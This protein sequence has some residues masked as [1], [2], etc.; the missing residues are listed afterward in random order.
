MKPIYQRLRKRTLQ[1]SSQLPPSE[2]HSDFAWASDR[3]AHTLASHHLVSQL[4]ESIAGIIDDD[5]GHGLHHTL[6]VTLDAGILMLVEGKASGLTG[7]LLDRQMVLAQCAGLLHDVKRK[8]ADHSACGAKFAET[9]LAP[10]PLTPSEI[11]DI[12]LAIRN[13]EA[14][15]AT[16]D[17]A[18]DMGQLVS[19]CLYDAD[20]FQWGPPNFTKTLWDMV[21]YYDPP[22]ESFVAKFPGGMS[23]ITQIRA[24]FRT[25][26]G[27]KYGP[28]IIDQGLAIGNELYRIMKNEFGL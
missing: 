14:F 27:R 13:H 24:T 8:E 1:L 19:D 18:S 26:T 15:K 10:Y 22:V 2:F 3:S 17:A 16:V 4:Q 20:K 7:R 11:H 9:L 21:A 23:R 28:P 6:S 5:L 25:S 12:C